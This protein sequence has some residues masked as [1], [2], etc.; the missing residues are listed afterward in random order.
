MIGEASL[1]L[2]EFTSTAEGKEIDTVVPLSP[3]TVASEFHPT[4]KVCMP[5][6]I[7]S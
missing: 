7:L 1:N 2:A 4:L 5:S 3:A 6:L